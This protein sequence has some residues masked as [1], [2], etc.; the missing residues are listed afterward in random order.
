MLRLLLLISTCWT[1]QV[2]SDAADYRYSSEV[3]SFIH[4]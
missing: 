4:S 2:G 1:L 3:S